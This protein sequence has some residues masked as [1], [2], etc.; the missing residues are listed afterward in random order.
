LT[1]QILAIMDRI[2]LENKM[3][4]AMTAYKVIGTDLEQGFLEFNANCVTLAD[5]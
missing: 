1:L 5:I 4:L 2:W 3:D